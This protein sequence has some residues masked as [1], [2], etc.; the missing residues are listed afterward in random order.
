MRSVAVQCISARDVNCF[1]NTTYARDLKGKILYSA[2]GKPRIDPKTLDPKQYIGNWT[3][4]DP[5]SSEGKKL[6]F[7]TKISKLPSVEAIPIMKNHWVLT[8]T[9]GRAPTLEHNKPN[10]VLT[11]V[12]R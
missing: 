4:V 9:L 3:S 10:V 2:D 7:I 8:W 6:A 1:S 12:G 5:N 11:Y